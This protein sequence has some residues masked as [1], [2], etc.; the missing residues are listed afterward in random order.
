MKK[1][2]NMKHWIIVLL[3]IPCAYILFQFINISDNSFETENVVQATFFDSIVCKGI[4]GAN[5]TVIQYNASGLIGYAVEDGSRVNA[6]DVIANVFDSEQQMLQSAKAQLLTSEI[7]TIQSSQITAAGTDANM[8]LN[9]VYT[10]LHSYLQVTCSTSLNNLTEQKL[11]LQLFSN[12]AAIVTNQ[13]SDFTS[14]IDSLKSELS[15]ISNVQSTPITAPISGYFVSAYNSDA[16]IYN[17]QQLQQMT[18]SELFTAAKTQAPA[19]NI[20]VAGKII[21]DY[22]WSFFTSVPIQQADKFKEGMNVEIILQGANSQPLAANVASVV[23][24]EQAELAKI[25]IVCNYINKDVLENSHFEAE[26]RF[27]QYEGLRINKNALRVIDGVQGVYIQTGNR[28][29]FCMVN[30][31]YENDDYILVPLKYES[32]KNEIRMYDSAIISGKELYDGKQI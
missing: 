21:H 17:L 16:L 4:F 10:A 12:K 11:N 27:D 1:K 2:F 5:E 15:A 31:I 30:I 23:I 29:D 7:E 8:I 9:Q 26:I 3:I 25:E 22:T 6:G 14:T 20:D 19:N 18:A 13:S 24:D 32:D 28:I